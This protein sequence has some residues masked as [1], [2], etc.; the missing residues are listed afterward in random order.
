[1]A[2]L[3]VIG[4]GVGGLGFLNA[5]KRLGRVDNFS[6]ITHIA[7]SQL[8]PPTSLRSTGIAGLRGTRQGLSPL[9]DEQVEMWHYTKAL[10]SEKT[11][12]G[13]TPIELQSWVYSDKSH[14]R[15]GHLERASFPHVPFKIPPRYVA[16]EEAWVVEPR[17]FLSH[18]ELPPLQSLTTLVNKIERKSCWQVS[19]LGAG[20]IE[21]DVLVLAIG[22]W[23]EW[24]KELTTGS[25]LENLRSYQGSYAEWRSNAYSKS[26]SVIIE[27]ANLIFDQNCERLILGAT[28]VPDEWSF[29]P[30][31][32]ALRVIYDRFINHAQIDLPP[33]SEAQILTGL[34]PQ[35]RGRVP[36][37]GKLSDGLYAV[38]G[39][40]KNGWVAAWP[41]GERLVRLIQDEAI[42]LEAEIKKS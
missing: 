29:I 39:L 17:T 26:F 20:V 30:D 9:G 21:A 15:Y 23:S 16:R 8:A 7:E 34:R 25:P 40:Y 42:S 37:A 3:C 11:W 33:L 24:F 38:G 12:P 2:R 6:S 5:L 13:L 19:T 32:R 10:F 4:G 28:S 36:W 14:R 18:V 1:M 31:H 27:G 22:V 35:T 41:L